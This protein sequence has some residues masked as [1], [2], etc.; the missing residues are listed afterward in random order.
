VDLFVQE[1]LRG[2]G[3]QR[4]KILKLDNEK[5]ELVHCNTNIKL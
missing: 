1:K 3:V 5:A 2:S 4:E